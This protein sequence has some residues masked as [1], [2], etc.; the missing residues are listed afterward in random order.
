MY[1]FLVLHY[2]NMDT[3]DYRMT[4]WT[5][6]LSIDLRFDIQKLRV[7]RGW[8]LLKQNFDKKTTSN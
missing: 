5:K 1:Y 2:I 8:L 7:A 6:A 3:G 4:E